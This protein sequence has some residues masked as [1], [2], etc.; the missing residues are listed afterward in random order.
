[1]ALQ[2]PGG[3]FG[4]LIT[5][6]LKDVKNSACKSHLCNVKNPQLLEFTVQGGDSTGN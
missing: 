6:S 3:I 5:E 1:M 2:M 4:S